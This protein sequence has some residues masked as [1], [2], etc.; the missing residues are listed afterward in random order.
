MSPPPIP[1]ADSEIA[2]WHVTPATCAAK[3]LQDG[4]E[5]RTG[6]RSRNARESRKAIY[7][8]PDGLSLNDGLSNWLADEF[9]D[10]V[11]LS[12]LE[13]RIPESWFEPGV[14]RWEAVI[15]REAPPERIRIL[16]SDI[17]DWNGVYPDSAAPPGW[18]PE[19]DSAADSAPEP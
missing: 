18:L 9:P 14:L 16:V 12:V 6:P 7:V 11:T 15:R 17:D 4:L 10:H 3:I 8:F 2:V 19:E 5:P 1:A 13:L